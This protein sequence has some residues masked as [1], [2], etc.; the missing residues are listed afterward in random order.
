MEVD[1]KLPPFRK[2]VNSLRSEPDKFLLL[3]KMLIKDHFNIIILSMGASGLFT[4]GLRINVFP[5]PRHACEIHNIHT[6]NYNQLTI[7]LVI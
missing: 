1:M 2:L 4:V 6:F 7:F 3:H 5:T